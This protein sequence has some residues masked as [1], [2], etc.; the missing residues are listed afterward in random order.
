MM[1]Q[2]GSAQEVSTRV[3]DQDIRPDGVVQR[4]AALGKHKMAQGECKP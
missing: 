2:T 3:G 1:R 4:D